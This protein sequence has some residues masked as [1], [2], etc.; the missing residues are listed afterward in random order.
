MKHARPCFDVSD[1]VVHSAFSARAKLRC[2]R[3]SKSREKHSALLTNLGD[4]NVI[5]WVAHSIGKSSFKFFNL[6]AMVL[7]QTNE[8]FQQLAIARVAVRRNL[9]YIAKI[10]SRFAEPI[11]GHAY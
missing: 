2:K 9:E 4:H 11:G 6:P 5:S 3:A 10:G 1:R 8:S 7:G